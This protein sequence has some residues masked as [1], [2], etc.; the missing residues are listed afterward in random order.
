MAAVTPQL[1]KELRELTGA[2]MMDCKNALNET[3]G[4]LDK[5]VQ[6]LREAGLGKA[7]KKAGN[8]AAEG[9]VAIEINSDNT[10]AVILELNAQT[11]FVAKNENFVN[12]TKEITSHALNNGIK[13]AQTLNS[14]TINGQEFSTFLAEKIATIGE[15]FGFVGGSFL[16]FVYFVLVYNMIK[17]VYDTKN[18]F[19]AY[20]ATGVIMMIVF[21]V[22]ENIGMNIGLLPV[23]GIPLPF[24]SQ[25]GSSLLGN[26][27]GIGLIMSMRFHHRSYMFSGDGESFHS[28]VK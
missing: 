27:M 9:L 16:I 14:S 11:D 1:I 24:V 15:N 5:A 22:L 6:A 13:D 28:G 20:I 12:L 4:D 19:Y 7:A 2:G 23:T 3:G 25:G 10:K 18:E 26:M 8:V 21:H 17:I